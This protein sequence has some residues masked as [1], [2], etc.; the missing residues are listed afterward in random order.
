MRIGGS[1]VSLAPQATT[2][3]SVLFI[4]VWGLIVASYLVYRRRN[5]GQ[6]AAAAAL[7]A[8]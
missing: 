7:A 6:I 5:P 4:F 3:A 1:P 8:S 2:V